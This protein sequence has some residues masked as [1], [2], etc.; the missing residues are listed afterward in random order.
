MFFKFRSPKKKLMKNYPRHF[1]DKM[2]VLGLKINLG[3][4]TVNKL[5]EK[6]MGS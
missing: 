6:F 2:F 4:K 1:S 3:T 5:T